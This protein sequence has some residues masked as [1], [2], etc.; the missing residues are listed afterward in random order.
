MNFFYKAYSVI[1]LIVGWVMCRFMLLPAHS[2]KDVPDMLA[3][4]GAIIIIFSII[5]NHNSTAR[6]A[7]LGYVVS[8][9]I[10]LL[11]QKKGTDPGG[12][13]TNT[14]WIVWIVSYALLIAYGIFIDIKISKQKKNK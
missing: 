1:Y 7:S 13:A 12:G 5:K 3:L 10:A 11:L 6:M 8:F 4:I 14:M 9:L 2:M